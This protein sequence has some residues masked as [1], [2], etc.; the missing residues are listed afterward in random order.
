MPLTTQ[1][2]TVLRAALNLA[3]D[4]PL[5]D[6]VTAAFNSTAEPP[7]SNDGDSTESPPAAGNDDATEPRRAPARQPDGTV[8]MDAST[9]EA[10]QERIKKLEA[11]D[12]K[13]RREERDQIINQAVKDRK[14]TPA[15]KEHWVRLWDADPEGT[16]ECI[17]GL[18]KN[19]MTP[20]ES[21][22]FNDYDDADLDDEYKHL[23]PP[24]AADVKGA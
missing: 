14:F 5:P 4:Q 7:Q 20:V 16:R 2:E 23:F 3:D 11:A 6:E 22:G 24:T 18:A 21:I 1:Q 19:I 15:R 13:R 10:S 8:V 9:W 12:A 17:A